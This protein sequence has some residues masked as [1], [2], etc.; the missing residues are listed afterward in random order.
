[1]HYKGPSQKAISMPCWIG[2]TCWRHMRSY[3][4]CWCLEKLNNTWTHVY[5]IHLI[6][7]THLLL[8]IHF[9]VSSWFHCGPNTEPYD[10]VIIIDFTHSNFY[11]C[12][13]I[14]VWKCWKIPT[15][16]LSWA[17]SKAR[18]VSQTKS[19]CSFCLCICILFISLNT[20]N[21]NQRFNSL[22]TLSTDV[23][24]A[25]IQSYLST[26]SN[27]SLRTSPVMGGYSV[28]AKM[29]TGKISDFRILQ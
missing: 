29:A 4:A 5:A 6:S 9:S 10:N 21:L 16:Q 1:M 14:Q 2:I 8:R 7:R 28:N 12:M 27:H 26:K 25:A 23:I 3:H 24:L 15:C 13:V 17:S 20:V 18:W 19:N 11:L 22:E